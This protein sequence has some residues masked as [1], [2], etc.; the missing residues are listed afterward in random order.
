VTCR[1]HRPPQLAPDSQAGMLGDRVGLTLSPLTEQTVAGPGAKRIAAKPYMLMRLLQGPLDQGLV[2]SGIG[3]RHNYARPLGR[4]WGTRQPLENPGGPQQNPG[5]CFVAPT[6][7][8]VL[9][10]F[11]ARLPRRYS[12]P[13]LGKP[14]SR[15]QLDG[16]RHVDSSLR[17]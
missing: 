4:T 10:Q 8:A 13:F 1:R 15:S 16:D 3:C 14:K 12:S 17:S 9:I 11:T 5:G 7:V 2:L 6:S